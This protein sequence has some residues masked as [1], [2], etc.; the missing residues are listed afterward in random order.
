MAFTTNKYFHTTIVAVACLV[1][2][3]RDGT[4]NHDTGNFGKEDDWKNRLHIYPCVV[5]GIKKLVGAGFYVVVAT[6]Q[7]GVA[8]GLFSEERVREVNSAI[9]SLLKEQ[10]VAVHGWYYSP[11]VDEEYALRNGISENFYVRQ[12]D[13]RKPGIGML[14]LAAADAGK[15]LEDF[16]GIYFVG[17]KDVDVLTGLNANGKGI[18]VVNEYNKKHLSRVA[19]LQK[20]YTGRVFVA[21]NLLEAADIIIHLA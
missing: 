4:I 3:D 2:L 20:L 6:N 18:F 9:D 15:K 11:F 8:H 19:D 12:D 7:A 10:G 17:D 14:R 21:N 13:L 16:S 5:E 1:G